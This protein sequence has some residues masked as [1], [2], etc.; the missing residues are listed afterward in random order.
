M[1]TFHRILAGVGVVLA[2]AIPASS[3]VAAPAQV[4]RVGYSAG[5]YTSCADE[6]KI[7]DVNGTYHLVTQTKADGSVT[8][9]LSIKAKGVRDDGM[10]YVLNENN[11]VKEGAD[12]SLILKDQF[13]VIRSG[14][15]QNLLEFVGFTISASGELT[16]TTFRS[17][18]VG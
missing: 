1:R 14:S 17:V 15:S 3:A 10:L 7:V 11:I 9:H 18:C 6:G 12:G 8:Y 13:R 5:F 16:L 2:T 4:D